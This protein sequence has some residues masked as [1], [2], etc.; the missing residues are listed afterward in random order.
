MLGASEPFLGAFNAQDCVEALNGLARLQFQ[1]PLGWLR[2]ALARSGQLL[3]SCTPADLALLAWALARLRSQPGGRWL[4]AWLARCQQGGLAGMQPR[5]LVAAAWAAATW[6]A[7]AAAVGD[8]GAGGSRAAPAG[9]PWRQLPAG[10]LPGMPS[11]TAW[12]I[13]PAQ[14]RQ[15]A[16]PL[17]GFGGA[18]CDAAFWQLPYC[19]GGEL[20]ALL[21]S[22][23]RLDAQ[24]DGMWLVG[25]LHAAWPQLQAC[26]WQELAL[27]AHAFAALRIQPPKRWLQRHVHLLVQQQREQQR[28]LPAHALGMA[29]WGLCELALGPEDAAWLG[30]FAGELAPA[31]GHLPPAR[32]AAMAGWLRR[33]Q[34]RVGGDDA[35]MGA[36]IQQLRAAAAEKQ[37]GLRA[38]AAAA[39]AGER[40][41][42]EA[43]GAADERLRLPLKQTAGAF[44]RPVLLDTTGVLAGFASA[45]A[46]QPQLVSASGLA[47]QAG[48]AASGGSSSGGGGSSSSAS[49]SSGSVNVASTPC[50]DTADGSVAL[51][52]RSGTS[53]PGKRLAA[54]GGARRFVAVA[55]ATSVAVPDPL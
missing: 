38:A 18:L 7:A 2:Q 45:E 52:E 41:C 25:L 43:A 37:Q 1:P 51:V 23:G 34:A 48:D 16:G 55:A 46:A 33:A 30:L 15:E 39:A 53:P 13:E 47:A 24:P 36:A 10:A 44:V 31:A 35:A 8:G 6:H 19:R 22:M 9:R 26:S 28:R 5:E 21:H 12:R 32:L 49:S 50:A 11:T 42:G 4:P 29:T 54:A 14:P 3:G 20:A 17:A 40:S 27:A